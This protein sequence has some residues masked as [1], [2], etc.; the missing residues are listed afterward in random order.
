MSY[1]TIDLLQIIKYIFAINLIFN[2]TI[3]RKHSVERCVGVHNL[4]ARSSVCLRHLYHQHMKAY[5]SSMSS[6]T[7]LPIH[8]GLP[9]LYVFVDWIN[10]AL[11]LSTRLENAVLVC[12]SQQE[13]LHG[14][15]RESRCKSAGALA[16]N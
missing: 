6:S 5:R 2:L 1:L 12:I 13:Q 16:G 3:M 15:S 8:Q 10:K 4:I 7:G 14:E 9:D 11:K